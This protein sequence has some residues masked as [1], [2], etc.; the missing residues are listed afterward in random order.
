[1]DVKCVVPF[2]D[3]VK[4][5]LEQFGIGDIRRGNIE[6]KR[7]LNIGVGINSIIGVVGGIKGNIAYSMS[8]QTA[9]NIISTMMMGM[10]VETI[11]EIGKSAIGELSN[12]ITGHASVALADNGYIINITPP[13]IMI[14]GSGDSIVSFIETIAIDLETSLGMIQVNIGIEV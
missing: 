12:M 14:N 6:K 7:S 8:E 5:T 9:K 10:P 13:V 4:Y 2:L 11:D 3:A 1:M